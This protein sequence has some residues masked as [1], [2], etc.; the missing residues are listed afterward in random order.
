MYA[1]VNTFIFGQVIYNTRINP[2]SFF[3]IAPPISDCFLG[4][5]F[6]L[7]N[8]IFHVKYLRKDKFNLSV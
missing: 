8:K 3:S 6:N 4:G 2:I 1:Y 5:K 7:E